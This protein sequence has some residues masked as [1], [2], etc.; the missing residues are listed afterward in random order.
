MKTT[1]E[2]D[3]SYESDDLYEWETFQKMHEYRRAVEDAQARIRAIRKYENPTTKVSVLL[4]E[5][6]E[7]LS[8]E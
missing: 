4:E 5:L 2:F 6:R 1:I 7:L 3:L 8:V